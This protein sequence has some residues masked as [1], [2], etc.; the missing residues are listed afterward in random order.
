ML[1]FPAGAKKNSTRA[2]IGKSFPGRRSGA[3]VA[4]EDQGIGG[5]ATIFVKTACSLA[6]SQSVQT[7][8]HP[9]PPW[10]ATCSVRAPRLSGGEPIRTES[11][12]QAQLADNGNAGSDETKA[13]RT[14]VVIEHT[15]PQHG[16]G[17]TEI[18]DESVTRNA[19]RHP[20][21]TFAAGYVERNRRVVAAMVAGIRRRT[22]RQRSRVRNDPKGT[23]TE[24]LERSR[25]S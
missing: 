19:L 25:S 24:D 14:L 6:C 2:A 23:A 22:R 4:F 5:K 17:A 20:V 15:L 13:P 21:A 12:E 7:W 3:V 1:S 18:G 10:H 8:R 9:R 16:L 11:I